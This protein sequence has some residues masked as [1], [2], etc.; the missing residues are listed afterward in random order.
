MHPACLPLLLLLLPNSSAA[1]TNQATDTAK[2]GPF[3][4]PAWVTMRYPCSNT[5][6]I[7]G[8]EYVVF[9]SPGEKRE[10][11]DFV[12][13]STTLVTRPLTHLAPCFRFPPR[14]GPPSINWPLAGYYHPWDGQTH[15]PLATAPFTAR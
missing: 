11:Q 13:L 15:T 5:P 9:L 1:I 12:C 8:V 6:K 7:T 4:G 3:P 2:C 10:K 14:L